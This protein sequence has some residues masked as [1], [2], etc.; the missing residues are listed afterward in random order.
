MSRSMLFFPPRTKRSPFAILDKLEL[1]ERDG[2][3]QDIDADHH[4][5]A[6]TVVVRI[7][8]YENDY[9]PGVELA[10]RIVAI[11]AFLKALRAIRDDTNSSIYDLR[12]LARDALEG[13]SND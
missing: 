3:M 5:A 7:E 2:N 9:E 4:G 10:K 6:A 1:G 11:P 8:G 12:T 13:V